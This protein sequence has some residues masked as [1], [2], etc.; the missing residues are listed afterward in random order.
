LLD[1]ENNRVNVNKEPVQA[2]DIAVLVRKSAE[3]TILQDTLSENGIASVIKSRVSVFES[4][5]ATGL[6]H[7]LEA[8]QQYFSALMARKGLTSSLLNH[9]TAQIQSILNDDHC[10]QHWL[11]QL[12]SLNQ[13]WSQRGFI[14]MFQQAQNIL[15]PMM[16]I[17]EADHCERRLTNYLHL[18][19]ILQKQSRLTSSIDHLMVWFKKQIDSNEEE[20]TRLRLESDSDLVVISTIHNSKGLEY[21]IVFLPYPWS[22]SGG[23]KDSS[24]IVFCHDQN[25]QL[26]ADIGSSELDEHSFRERLESMSEDMRILYV[27]LTRARSKLYLSWGNV[28][29]QGLSSSDAAL[30][31]LIHPTTTGYDQI[32]R[33]IIKF[34]SDFDVLPDLVSLQGSDIEIIQP[35]SISTIEPSAT[36][37]NQ[38]TQI[39]L[40][41]VQKM[42][43]IN[44]RIASF[45]SLTRNIHQRPHG[46]QIEPGGDPILDF[47]AGSRVGLFLH[48][49]LENIDFTVDLKSQCKIWLPVLAPAY[50]FIVDQIS[51]LVLQWLIEIVGCPLDDNG[52]SLKH[53]SPDSRLN[54]LPFDFAFNELRFSQLNEL[55]SRLKKTQPEPIEL[56]NFKGLISG[57]I[58]LVFVNNGR[59]Y[60]ADYK[61]NF[62]GS[63][64]QD[65]TEDKLEQA[66]VDRRY[67][68]QSLI[69]SLAVHR[70]LATRI[71]D[72]DYDTHFGG[73]YYLFLRAMRINSGN[74][75]GVYIDRPEKTVIHELDR[76]FGHDGVFV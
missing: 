30:S 38:H 52:L 27:A 23:R 62:L 3:A 48:E 21:P 37:K 12:K 1:K 61:S 26:V 63:R 16:R 11:D 8:I 28:R 36:T 50:G 14:Q 17:A 69:Y 47:V 65:Y 7:L 60:L 40:D 24:R 68:L 53:L 51:T 32:N 66:I 43:L 9:D 39:T 10:W 58:D 35:R 5:E 25:H 67:D 18:G 22:S 33:V 44:W 46:G 64:L 34:E 57:V 2:G 71:T 49:L 19:E 41:R 45:S 59:Y 72:Y 29:N 70:Y 75:Y 74:S 15:S 54:E 76:I 13:I 56:D 42:S 55:C 73:S 20:E 31:R 6:Y 4:D